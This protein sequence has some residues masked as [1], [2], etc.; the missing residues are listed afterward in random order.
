MPDEVETPRILGL[1]V[2]LWKVSAKVAVG[3]GSCQSVDQGVAQ[4]VSI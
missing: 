1:G 4:H 3:D 2:I